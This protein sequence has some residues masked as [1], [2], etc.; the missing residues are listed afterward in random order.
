MKE[1][2]LGCGTVSFLCFMI[3]KYWGVITW[4]WWWITAPIWIPIAI[5]PAVVICIYAVAA[6]RKIANKSK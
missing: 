1:C 2:S 4:S 6:Y 5:I 3:L